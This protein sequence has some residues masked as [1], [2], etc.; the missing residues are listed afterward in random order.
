MRGI[1]LRRWS[2]SFG[3]ACVL[4]LVVVLVV[5]LCGV[6]VAGASEGTPLSI[7]KFTM[8]TTE[9]TRMTPLPPLGGENFEVENVPYSF[10]QA[11]GHPWGLTSAFEF[12]TE[13]PEIKLPTETYSAVVADAGPEG[14]GCGVAAGVV[15]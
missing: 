13:E 9:Q 12:A 7:T 6:G 10:T 5:C 8:Q 1:S 11:G 4:S 3:W 14:C 2:G 15:G